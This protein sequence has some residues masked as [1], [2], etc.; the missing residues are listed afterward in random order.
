VT[1]TELK[2]RLDRLGITRRDAAKALGLTE[3]GLF[4]QMSG[5]RPVSR[6]TEL[7]LEILEQKIKPRQQQRR[8]A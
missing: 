4:H 3:R 8:V 1:N 5:D 6:Q 7:L 2:T